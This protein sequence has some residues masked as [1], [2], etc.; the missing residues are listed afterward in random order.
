MLATGLL[1]ATIDTDLGL[2]RIALVCGY[3]NLI[4]EA[5]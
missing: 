1:G 5:V 4:E 2:A 3:A